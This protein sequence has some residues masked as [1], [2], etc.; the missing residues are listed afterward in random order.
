MNAWLDT[1]PSTAHQ[2]AVLD[3]FERSKRRGRNDLVVLRS[4]QPG[5]ER[6]ERQ[7]A[8]GEFDPL[9]PGRSTVTVLTKPGHL[10]YEWVVSYRIDP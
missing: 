4:W 5:K 9:E 10:G 7:V 1:A 6:E 3:K 2:A 8:R